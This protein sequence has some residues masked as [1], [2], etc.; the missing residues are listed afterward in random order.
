MES[1]IQSCNSFEQYPQN[2]LRH[3]ALS[4]T[5]KA[6]SNRLESQANRLFNERQAAIDL[7]NINCR[8]GGEVMNI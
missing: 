2:I 6:F 8:D 4:H 3:D 7:L 1:L 5:L